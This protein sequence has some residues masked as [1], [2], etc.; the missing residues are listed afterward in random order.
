MERP[1]GVTALGTLLILG[2][3]GLGLFALMFLQGAAEFTRPVNPGGGAGEWANLNRNQHGFG[4][5]VAFVCMVFGPPIALLALLGYEILKLRNWARWTA[6]ILIALA[7]LVVI[8]AAMTLPSG[9]SILIVE[10]LFAAALLWLLIYLCK[11][12]VKRAFGAS[13]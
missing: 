1:A 5:L 6:I 3:V 11:P 10:L 7:L 4:A 9:P 12:H 13:L 2:A 8:F